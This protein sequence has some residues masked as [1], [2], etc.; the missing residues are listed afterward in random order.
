MD[1]CRSAE[2]RS[3]GGCLARPRPH[4]AR[5]A[6]SALSQQRAL[7]EVCYVKLGQQKQLIESLALELETIK[8]I[9]GDEDDAT[10]WETPDDL[11]W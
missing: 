6:P 2:V 5:S 9:L 1:P 7:I 11:R 8:R 3:H 10:G 4:H